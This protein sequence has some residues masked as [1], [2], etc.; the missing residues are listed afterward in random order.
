MILW[1]AERVFTS[2]ESFFWGGK[3]DGGARRLDA[4]R[5]AQPGR[6]SSKWLPILDNP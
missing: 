5:V 1:A 6:F 3:L 4:S 2:I